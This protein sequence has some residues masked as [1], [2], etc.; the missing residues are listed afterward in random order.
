MTNVPAWPDVTNVPNVTGMVD[1]TDVS[2]V[3][4]L[5]SVTFR[6]VTAEAGEIFATSA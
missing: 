4:D 2:D 5:T 1:P 3:T 6:F